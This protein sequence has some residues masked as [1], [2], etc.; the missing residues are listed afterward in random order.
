MSSAKPPYR[1]GWIVDSAPRHAYSLPW[2]RMGAV[3]LI[4]YGGIARYLN[5]TDPQFTMERYLPWRHYAAVVVVK[6]LNQSC[7]RLTERLQKKGVRVLFDSNVNYYEEWGD[8]QISGTRPTPEQKSLA[9]LMTRQADVVIADSV[10]LQPL[11]RALNPKTVYI[12]DAVDTDVYYPNP[13]R[14]T[15]PSRLRLIWSGVSKKA[16][17]LRLVEEALIR[18]KDQLDLHLVISPPS[19]NNPPSPVIERLRIA[20]NARISYFSYATYPQHLREAD[21]IISP[22]ILSSSYEMGHTEYKIALGMAT[23][24]PALASPQPSYKEAIRHGQEGWICQTSEEWETAF[25]RCIQNPQECQAIGQR[26]RKRIEDY[27]SIPV[28]AQQYRQVLLETLG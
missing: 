28:V 7:L 4:R 12:P 19:P 10:Y 8:F 5:R 1:I 2:Q 18:L 23:A 21:V 20:M 22:K 13:E 14:T 26:A 15:A 17:H 25:K 9:E 3:S 27:Y 24:L 16:H 11:C 6:K